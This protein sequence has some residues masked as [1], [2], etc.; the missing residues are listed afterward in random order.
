MQRFN[1]HLL[2]LA[3]LPVTER[4]IPCAFTQ[5]IVKLSKMLLSLGHEVYLYGPEGSDAPCTEFVQTHTLKDIRDSWGEGDNR[6]ELGYDWTK[7]FKNDFNKD[8]T[9]ATE[10]Y[11]ANCIEEIGLRL[12]KDDFLLISQ[13]T[14]QKKIYQALNPYLKLEFGIGYRGSDKGNFRAFESSYIQNF[15]YGSEAPRQSINGR[16]YDRVI[17]NYFD[18][19]DFETG[20]KEDYYL[21]IGRLIT[22]KGVWTAIKATEHIGAKLILTGQTDKEIDI[23]KL[24]KH[25]EY[26]GVSNLEQRK[27]LM[28]HAIAT[29]VPSIYLEPF[30]GTHVE[31][32]LSGVPPITTNFG[33][34]PETI[35]DNLRGKVGFRCDTLMDF[36]SAAK[37]AHLVD[38]KYVREYAKRFEM[39]TVKY[40]FQ[41]W[42][43]DLYQLYLSTDGKTKGWHYL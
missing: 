43:G 2:G 33:V 6:F 29:F 18:P 21:Y 13:G 10:K 25:C 36:V 12:K 4:Y 41:K 9:Q 1:F 5:K 38:R 40:E 22:R 26:V 19:K 14:Y 16:Y 35:P 11:Y 32:M 15:T 17:P 20:E 28:A 37:A 27:K 31:S 34:F 24:P 30:A 39:D 42:F 23:K 8:R 3:H 7:G